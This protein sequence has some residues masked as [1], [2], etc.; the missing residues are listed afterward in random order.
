MTKKATSTKTNSRWAVRCKESHKAE[1]Q[2]LFG[3]AQGGTFKDLRKQS[4][5]NIL[6]IGFDGYAIGG[7]SVGEPKE[8][9]FEIM[10]Y[11]TPLL[12]DDKPRYVMGVGKPEDII[13]GVLNGIDM[14]DCVIPT[15]N[16]RN[17]AMFTSEGKVI[18]KNSQYADDKS[19][20][21]PN[22]GCY[23]CRNFSR[24]YLRHLFLS[25]EILSYRLNTIHNIFFFQ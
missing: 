1:N 22:C 12:P 5:E 20:I 24:A 15:R 4:V 3:I 10:E 9:M 19:P 18:I 8:L 2:A 6:E 13:T 21:D 17:G 16:A 14:F 11:A 23:T 7:V 25:R